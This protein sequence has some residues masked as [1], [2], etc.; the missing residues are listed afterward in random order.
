MPTTLSYLAIAALPQIISRLSPHPAT[1]ACAEQQ[2]PPSPAGQHPNISLFS[3][4]VSSGV[5][6]T[7]AICQQH[8]EPR[9]RELF[10]P[11]GCVLCMLCTLCAC[12]G[13]HCVFACAGHGSRFNPHLTTLPFVS[14]Q[15]N[16]YVFVVQACTPSWVNQLQVHG[17]VHAC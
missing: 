11:T 8:R 4:G 12:V 13:H 3:S 6:M 5:I 2:P 10:C 7:A 14:F 17:H 15:Y 1:P 16:V 9:V